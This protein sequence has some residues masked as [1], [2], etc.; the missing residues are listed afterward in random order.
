MKWLMRR[1]REK[2]SRLGDRGMAGV[3]RTDRR[4]NGRNDNGRTDW[5]IGMGMVTNRQTDRQTDH[6]QAR[7]AERQINVPTIRTRRQMLDYDD[8]WATATWI[9]A[10]CDDQDLYA[11]KQARRNQGRV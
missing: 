3:Q 9:S 7:Q 6:R 11:E 10:T 2:V 5:Q 1:D 8:R 4:A